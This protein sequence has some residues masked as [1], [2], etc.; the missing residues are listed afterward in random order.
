MDQLDR[1]SSIN[2]VAD[3]LKGRQ[4]DDDDRYKVKNMEHMKIP[5]E[6]IISATSN[7]HDDFIIGRGGFG[8]VYKAHLFH[9]DLRKYST[10]NRIYRQL[11]VELSTYPRRRST[12]AIKRLDR[13]YGQGTSEFLQE[14]SILPYFRHQNLV[15]LVGFCD[16]LHE[17]I[18]VY[19]YASNGG[20][21]RYIGSAR[22]LTWAQRLQI[23][24]D[25]AR[26]LDFLHN[27]VG[28]HHRIIHRDIKSSNILISRNWTGMISDFG[29]SRISPANLQATFVMTQVAGT[30]EY[31]DPQYHKTGILT[32]ESDA[33]SFGVV[34][35]EVLSGRLARFGIDKVNP[36][37]VPHMAKRCFKQKKVHEIIDPTLKKEF[38]INESCVFDD[39][40]SNPESINIYAAIAYQCLQHKPEDRPTM[41]NIVR[42]LE[43]ALKSH[44]VIFSKSKDK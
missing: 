1:I 36:E 40:E 9:F 14:I 38:K 30:L 42:Q 7:F 29:L 26:G 21:D 20:L 18:L 16:E 24:L 17:R 8:N 31:I 32:K 23:C 3:D 2:Q 10:E 41:A 44:S 6:D 19:E 11:T 15:T 37:F 13:R 28:D 5:L 43:K 4:E 25:A 34:L 33:Y 22:S 12:V 35:F 27:G 39:D